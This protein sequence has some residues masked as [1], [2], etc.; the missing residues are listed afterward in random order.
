MR[1]SNQIIIRD[2]LIRTE[3]DN[4]SKTYVNQL[5]KNYSVNIIK[6]VIGGFPS[7]K[8]FTVSSDLSSYSG[9]SD[10][11]PNSNNITMEIL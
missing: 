9:K 5:H 8:H 2:L 11:E 6:F 7:R 1:C 3:T 10:F 4:A